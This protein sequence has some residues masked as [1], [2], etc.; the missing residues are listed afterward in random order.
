VSARKIALLILILGLGATLETVWSVRNQVDIGP[1]GCRVLGGRFYGP[2]W[3]FEDESRAEV[4]EGTRVEVTNAFGG[5]TVAAGEPG[6]VKVG[7]R[8]V[9]YLPTEERARDF[10][11]RV[12]L[13]AERQGDRME[14]GT[15]RDALSREE[16]VGLETHL[17]LEVPPG[18]PVVVRNDHGRVEVA[19]VSRADLTASYEGVQVTRVTGP[20]EVR[21]RHG[22]ASVSE[23][24][25]DLVLDARYGDVA[26]EG[27]TGTARLEARHGRVEVRRAGA[28]EIDHSHG[29]VRVEDVTGD[30][31][32]RGAHAGVHVRNVGGDADVETSYDGVDLAD[33]AGEARL[34]TA[35]GEV[36]ATGVRGAL[37][38]EASYNR[39]ELQDVGG[40]IDV[41]VVHGGVQARDVRKGGRIKA[42]GDDV[43]LDGFA[44]P[45]E[46]ETE[47]ASVDLAPLGPITERVSVKAARGGIRLVV[48][49]GS[50][51]DLVAETRRGELR[52][53]LPGL[54]VT[55]SDRRHVS[56]T[57][58]GGGSPVSLSADGDV[59]L[60]TLAATARGEP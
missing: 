21:V 24:G 45:L 9:V 8:K 40:P 18:T 60:E 39:V 29:D 25:G 42:S 43:S 15:N 26:V 6:R 33:V 31:R 54:T 52:A 48:P 49:A 32:V 11:R 19:D 22:G 2:S 56:G 10:S 14:V 35:H 3:T 34:K 1:E 16:R 36:K 7:L 58:A 51:F 5:V 12:V 4:P 46:V 41:V 27:V 55:R 20:V 59:E 17:E 50:R 53:D 47:R 44:G 37:S 23:V 30:V 57:L 28:V 38:V 13:R